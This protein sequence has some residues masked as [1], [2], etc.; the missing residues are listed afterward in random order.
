MLYKVCVLRCRLVFKAVCV[1]PTLNPLLLAPELERFAQNYSYD[2]H[3]KH[4]QES[5][6]LQWMNAVLAGQHTEQ[7]LVLESIPTE[8]VRS[9]R[10]VHTET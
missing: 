4:V 8:T 10:Y 5:G 9:L 3:G 7:N 6:G 2:P 1:R